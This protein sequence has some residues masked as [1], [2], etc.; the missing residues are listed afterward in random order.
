MAGSAMVAAVI[1]VIAVTV[2]ERG[3]TCQTAAGG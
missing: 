2:K 1:A 3:K